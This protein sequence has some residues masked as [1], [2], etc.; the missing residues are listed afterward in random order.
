MRFNP[1]LYL[2]TDR[3]HLNGRDFLAILE[4]ALDGGVT[5]IQLREKTASS[6]EFYE[7]ARQV[8]ELTRRRNVP[9]WI[10]DRLDIALAVHAD[11]VHLGQKD[12]PAS[13]ARRLLPS[14]MLMGVTAATVELA[15]QAERDGAD[16]IGSGAVFP[17]STKNDTRPLPLETLAAI[18][19]AVRIPVVAIGGIGLDNLHLPLSTGVDGVAVVSAIMNAPD[20]RAAAAALRTQIDLQRK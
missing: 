19:A 1:A 10:D 11:G 3:S 5:M 17:T 15:Q 8:R 12:L 20:A 2:V 6:R 4:Q 13:A 18:K 14:E 16:L 9:L 7:L